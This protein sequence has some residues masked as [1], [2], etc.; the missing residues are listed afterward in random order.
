MKDR[1]WLIVITAKKANT[2][3]PNHLLPPP[4]LAFVHWQS[5]GIHVSAQT[6]WV[7]RFCS[8]EGRG[9]EGCL[10][11]VRI[12][13]SIKASIICES[14]CYFSGMAPQGSAE[15]ANGKEADT[16]PAARVERV[17]DLQCQGE[18]GHSDIL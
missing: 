11:G 5:S 12:Q 16:R 9:E 14:K 15:T 17:R 3:S 13:T 1:F 4:V 18:S 2:I 6:G 10:A 7:W 8:G